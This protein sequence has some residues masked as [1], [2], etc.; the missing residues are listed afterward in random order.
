MLGGNRESLGPSS[1]SVG[2]GTLKKREE[3]ADYPVRKFVH[4]LR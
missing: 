4:D 1:L 2:T 3:F